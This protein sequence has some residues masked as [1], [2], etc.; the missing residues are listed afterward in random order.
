[1]KVHLWKD[2]KT[3]ACGRKRQTESIAALLPVTVSSWP[4]KETC[5][6]CRKIAK[7]LLREKKP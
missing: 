5:K 3:M 7:K 1:M 4:L 6:R 2:E